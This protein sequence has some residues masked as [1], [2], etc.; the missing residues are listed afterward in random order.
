MRN[1]FLGKVRLHQ[2]K[3]NYLKKQQGGIHAVL[4]FVEIENHY[5]FCASIEN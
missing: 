3:I 2:G 1:A 5:K 4:F